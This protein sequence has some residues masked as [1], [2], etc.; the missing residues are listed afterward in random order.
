MFNRISIPDSCSY[1]MAAL[2]EPLAVVLHASRRANFGATPNPRVCVI[3]AGAVGLL[4]CSLSLAL[5]ASSVT[6]IDI[7]DAKLDFA[8]DVVGVQDTWKVPVPTKGSLPPPR[9]KD[10]SLQ[11]SRAL[12]ELALED[13][14]I[15]KGDGFDI[16]FECTGVE[17]C[18][19][20]AIFVSS[21]QINRE[22]YPNSTHNPSS[23]VRDLALP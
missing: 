8:R 9:D 7:D 20:M 23:L 22:H 4:A 13:L 11:R 19:Q 14:S 21:T 16:V 17:S 1:E 15:R 10:E 2:A 12:A 18:I 6:A 5:G 3:G